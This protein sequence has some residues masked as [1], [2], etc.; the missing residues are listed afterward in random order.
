MILKHIF[1]H[2][3]WISMWQYI[4]LFL[5][6]LMPILYSLTYCSFINSPDMSQ[7]KSSSFVFL[8]YN[9][10]YSK[11]SSFPYTFQ[12]Q[13]ANFPKSWDFAWNYMESTDKIRKIC[14]LIALSLHI[15]EHEYLVIYL[16]FL[17][18]FKETSCSFHCRSLALFFL[19]RVCF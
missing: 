19:N 17:Q 9:L 4:G 5:S 18:F 10:G 1:M 14:Y 12:S 15:H 16:G 8:Q 11:S 6:M 13:V 7:C 2:L 3:F